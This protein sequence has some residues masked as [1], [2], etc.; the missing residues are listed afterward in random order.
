MSSNNN[1]FPPK[2]VHSVV[3]LEFLTNK[4]LLIYFFEIIELLLPVSLRILKRF[5]LPFTVV[6][7]ITYVVGIPILARLGFKAT[8]LKDV[9]YVCSGL[10]VSLSLRLIYSS[11][12]SYLFEMIHKRP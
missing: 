5:L 8:S 12:L 7:P 4:L 1:N 10:L 6:S 9:E 3:V 2:V 11:G